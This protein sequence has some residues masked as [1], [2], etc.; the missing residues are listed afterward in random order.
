MIVL[1]FAFTQ[2]R[3]VQAVGSRPLRAVLLAAAVFLNILF[4]NA[5]VLSDFLPSRGVEIQDWRPINSYRTY[6]TITT[7]LR[8]IEYSSMKE[9]EGY[10]IA[11]VRE[12][13]DK[14]SEN[15]DA[16]A[17]G[18]SSG[19]DPAVEPNIIII[20]DEAFADLRVL[21]DLETSRDYMPVFNG[22]ND[23][24]VKGYY[25]ASTFGGGT[26]R[27][28]FELLTSC[29][30]AFLPVGAMPFET[31]IRSDLP[32]LPSTLR[33]LGYSCCEAIHPKEAWN[34]NR[35]EAYPSLGFEDYL[36]IEDLP[37]DMEKIHGQ[38][39]DQATYDYIIDMY[40]KADKDKPFFVYDLTMQNHSPYNKGDVFDDPVTITD[41]NYD[42]E[43]EEY[44]NLIHESDRALG[45]LIDYFSKDSRPTVILFM[46]DHQP[47]ITD[48]FLSS[49]TDGKNSEWTEEDSLIRYKTPFLIWASYDIEE[50]D[51]EKVSANY[52][53]SM[54][55]ETAGLRETDYQRYLSRLRKQ[56]PWINA[57]GYMGSDG[58]YYKADD[59]ASP[60][61]ESINEYRMLQY[62]YLFG[63]KNR[64]NDFFE[65]K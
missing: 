21:G 65:L 44:L 48:G 22:L 4:V 51:D 8:S 26:A 50:K 6:G 31:Y 63:G 28:E 24:T 52:L 53:Q 18:V 35:I 27:T 33:D 14:Y 25:Y 58:K 16:E 9:P 20:V 5:V 61:Y 40:E 11:A 47:R 46:G 38:V 62:N 54:L 49:V 43:A 32:A 30:S 15:R 7:F 19:L 29:T 39:S 2:I 13:T 36:S 12:I 34:Y 3:G 60:Y 64:E 57:L 1:A 41:D 10:S 37:D 56:V 42:P 23:N 17:A 59:T 45:N 55:F